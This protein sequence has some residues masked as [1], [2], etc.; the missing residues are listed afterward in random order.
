MKTVF[1]AKRWLCILP[2]L[3]LL[4]A[5][6]EASEPQTTNQVESAQTNQVTLDVYKS[7]TCGCCEGWVD[8]LEEAGFATL[9]HHSADLGLIKEQQGIDANIQSCHTAVSNNGYVFEG[10][11]PAAIM[12]RFLN[13]PPQDAMG[14]AVPGMPM[15]SPGMEMGDRYDDYAVLLI[16]KDGST[17]VYQQ[18]KGK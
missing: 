12:Q 18:V 5:C 1:K 3:L 9:L 15:G 4:P 11:I 14:L 2:L 16:K 13:D 17:E 6:Y 8:H 7:P 10:H